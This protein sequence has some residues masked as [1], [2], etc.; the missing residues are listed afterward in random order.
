VNFSV[1]VAQEADVKIL[2]DLTVALAIYERKQPE[3]IQLTEED[4]RKW[5]FGPNRIFEALI[6][7]WDGKPVGMAT[8]YTAFSGYL[9]APLLYLEDMFVLPD[10]RA[11]GI[12][13]ALLQKLALITKERGYCRMH[14]SVFNWNEPALRLYEHVGM[15]IR[16]EIFQARLDVE[17]MDVLLSMDSPLIIK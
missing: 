16:K 11:L 15:T 12:G 4:L 9:A 6:A 7:R 8:Y 5:G 10:Y 17:N 1:D 13:T 2:Y 3:D 14:L